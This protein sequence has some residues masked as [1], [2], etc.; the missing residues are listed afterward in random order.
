MVYK[1]EWNQGFN[2]K[3]SAEVVGNELSRIEEENGEVT[4][5]S[6]LET[7][8]SEESP[9]H[10]LFE[11][12]DTVAAEKYRL[13]QA[14][15]YIR[16]LVKTPVQGEEEKPKTFRAF[17]SVSNHEEKGRFVNAQK[18]L[19]QEETRKIVLNNALKELSAF[20]NKYE[21]LNELSGVF[22]AIDEVTKSQI[23]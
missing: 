12:N 2:L 14:G 8:R 6:F 23:D 1:Y 11:W 22:A 21:N 13:S 16:M 7:A 17:V 3:V 18:A 10:N 19:S 4:K 20:K 15:Y 9:L 5:E